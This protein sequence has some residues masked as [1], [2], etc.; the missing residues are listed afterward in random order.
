MEKI[1]SYY[2]LITSKVLEQYKE[3]DN[4]KKILECFSAEFDVLENV[5]FDLYI[6]RWLSNSVGKQLDNIGY[7][8]SIERQGLQDSDYRQIIYA[9]IGQYNSNG[10][11]NN[12]MDL[13]KLMTN[14]DF[15]VFT[16]IFPAK[17]NLAIIGDTLNLNKDFLQSSLQSAVA[18]GVKLDLI[19]SGSVP[20]FCYASETGAILP[21]QFSGYPAEDGST[22]SYYAEKL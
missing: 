20:V 6:K 12:I 2:N 16:E 19:I 22:V 5:F 15:V 11:I 3:K 4:F 18:G 17:I 13:A 21:I 9:R 7:N 14:A 10:T 8:L 1:T